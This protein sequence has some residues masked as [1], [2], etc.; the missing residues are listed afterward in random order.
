MSDV[1]QHRDGDYI[2]EDNT[3]D[4]S[5][6]GDGLDKFDKAVEKIQKG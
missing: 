2:L 4:K 5:D 3:N 1:K 6:D